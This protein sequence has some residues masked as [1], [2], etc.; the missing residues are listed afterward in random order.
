MASLGPT[1]A[2]VNGYQGLLH[3]G[4]TRIHL[5]PRLRMSGV[6][7]LLPPIRLYALYR[8]QFY[9][10]ISSVRLVLLASLVRAKKSNVLYSAYE[11]H[12]RTNCGESSK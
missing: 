1:K 8:G 4:Y 7:P 5:V 11:E 3:L 12:E 10:D 6:I 2:P 9:Y